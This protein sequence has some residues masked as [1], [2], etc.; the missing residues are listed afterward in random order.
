MVMT[1]TAFVSACATPAVNSAPPALRYYTPSEIVVPSAGVGRFEAEGR[2]VMFHY[3]KNR[4]RRAA[5]FPSGTRLSENGKSVLL[6][7]GQSIS[8]GTRVKIGFEAPPH[9]PNVDQ[10]CGPNPI[11]VLEVVEGE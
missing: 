8:F 9:K 2:C 3:A 11:E 1:A 5:L 7:N 4:F 10:S 6:P